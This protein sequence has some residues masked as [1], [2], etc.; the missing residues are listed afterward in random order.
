MP[1]YIVVEAVITD[2]KKFVGYAQVVPP[3]LEKFGGKYI[4]IKTE[5]EALEGDWGNTKLVLHEWPSMDTARRFWNSDEY[6]QAK[7]L[8]EGA[9]TFRVM[10]ID[11]VNSEALE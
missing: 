11:G 10:L 7:T 5:T 1:A 6:Q 9:G 2:P 4:A 8:R 3:L